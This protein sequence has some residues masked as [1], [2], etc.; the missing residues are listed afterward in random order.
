LDPITPDST[1][2]GESYC[3][4]RA[5]ERLSEIFSSSIAA[6]GAAGLA[7]GT[8]VALAARSNKALS[9]SGVI[10]AVA[11][12]TVT[13]AAGW[14]WGAILIAFFISGTLLSRIGE[15]RKRSIMADI[16]EKGSQ[17]DWRQ[18]LANGGVYSAA[19]LASL[20][21]PAFAWKVI[22]IGAIAAC[23]S[24]TW[25]TEI[26][27]LSSSSA[28]SIKSFKRVPP[29]T[30]GG[31]T[32]TGT[33]ASL[34]GGIFI[35]AAALLLGWPRIVI[36]SA[37]IGGFLGAIFDSILGAT[38]QRRRWCEQCQRGTE[39]A[40]HTCGKPTMDIGGIAWLDNDGVNLVSSMFG[41][42]V[43]ATWLL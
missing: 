30:S 37:V 32:L 4:L 17:R 21:W 1:G 24:D 23:T 38:L 10:A 22:G 8:L 13:C 18:V 34:A 33:L 12:A 11:V 26:G 5:G 41:A 43:G 20:A 7:L 14:S 16:V 35:A 25:A 15:P 3:K 40:V 2:N 36:P 9:N 28:R 31:I 19:A 39:R 6:R 29:G 42:L 27:T